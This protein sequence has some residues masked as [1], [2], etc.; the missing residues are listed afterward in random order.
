[1]MWSRRLSRG[2]CQIT[3]PCSSQGNLHLSKGVMTIR[4]V[5][6]GLLLSVE[7]I[8]VAQNRVD[9]RQD[10]RLYPSKRGQTQAGQSVL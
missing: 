6:L 1:M 2:A 9:G 10:M 5:S 7:Q 3:G 4:Q 8:Q